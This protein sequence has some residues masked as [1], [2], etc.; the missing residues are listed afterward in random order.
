MNDTEHYV[1]LK[2]IKTVKDKTDRT[3]TLGN[4]DLRAMRDEFLGYLQQLVSVV[5]ELHE[6]EERKA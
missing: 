1:L 6:K 4:D 3:Y 5:N 2:T